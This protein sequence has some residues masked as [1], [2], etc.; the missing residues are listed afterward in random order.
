[1]R[2]KR[3]IVGGD[4]NARTGEKGALEDGEEGIEKKSK[5]KMINRQGKGLIR[6]VEEEG[7]GIMNGTKEGDEKGGGE[8]VINYAKG[9]RK[10]WERVT[11]LEVGCE[12]DSDHQS[13]AVRVD[14]GGGGERRRTIAEERE[15]KE[16][17]KRVKRGAEGK[18]GWWDEDCRK[19]RKEVEKL[20]RN[21]KRERK[22]KEDYKKRK[23]EY[24]KMCE[25][26][27]EKKRNLLEGV[28]KA[29]TEK[30]VWEVIK[31]E[32][33]K[34]VEINKEITIEEWD[35]YLREM[36]EGTEYKRRLGEEEEEKQGSVGEVEKGEG[37]GWEELYL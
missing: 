3:W 20:L 23:K 32:R 1:R 4:F 33:R 35:E 8:T 9:D 11:R 10:V 17:M 12:V 14:K 31:K 7:W 21:W 13:V 34:R 36:L 25:R 37:I 29:R 19:K 2:K 6:W 27:K 22:Y 28:R 5:D 18:G 16:R 30:Q 15:M 24:K 26:K